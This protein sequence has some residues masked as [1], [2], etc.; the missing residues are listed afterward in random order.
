MGDA[1]F[2][3]KMPERLIEWANDSFF[4]QIGYEPE[5]CIGKTTKFLYPDRNTFL[6]FGSKLR[7]AIQAG[8]EIL[9]GEQLMKRKNGEI[10]PAEYTV[11]IIRNEK[12]EVVSAT[13]VAKDITTRIHSFGSLRPDPECGG[14]FVSDIVPFMREVRWALLV[15]RGVVGRECP[16]YQKILRL[17]RVQAKPSPELSAFCIWVQGLM[18]DGQVAIREALTGTGLKI[19]GYVFDSVYVLAESEQHLESGFAQVR[20]TLASA[21]APYTV[22]LKGVR[23]TTSSWPSMDG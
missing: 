23:A 2:S 14:G 1:V 22:K 21:A 8:E 5:E 11:T 4:R 15:I 9:R 7:N 19:M 16:S 3:A 18:A 12:G 17:D 10:F 20:N 13:G 6:D